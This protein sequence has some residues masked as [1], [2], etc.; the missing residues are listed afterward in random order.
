MKRIAYMLITLVPLFAVGAT[1]RLEGDRIWLDGKGA[2]LSTVLQMFEDRG[3]KVLVDPELDLD[4]L[5]GSWEDAKA[6][7]VISQLAGS[8]NYMVDWELIRGPLGDQYRLKSFRIGNEYTVR[9]L[10]RRILDVVEGPDGTK[11][12]RGEIMVSFKDGATVEDLNALLAKLGGTLLEF[13]DPPGIYRIKIG[14]NLSVE[15]AMKIAQ[16]DANV[17]TSEQNLAFPSMNVVGLPAS[18][19]TTD[20][21]NL[22]LQPGETAVAVLDSGLD[23]KYADLPFIRGTYNAVDPSA[24]IY[25]PTGHGTLTSLIASGALT[26][27]GATPSEVGVPVLSIM[28][29]DENGMTSAD[30][31]FR[32]IDFAINSGASIIN[33]SFGTGTYSAFL[34]DAV[35][36]AIA[37]GVEIFVSAGNHINTDEIW[38]AANPGVT[39]VGG[40]NPD[41]SVWEGSNEG[42]D[43]DVYEPAYATLEG[44]TSVGTSISS[45]RASHNSASS[46]DQA[47]GA[48][49]E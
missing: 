32:A 4:R 48:A 30:T 27:H 22:N 42:I 33:M 5:S 3:V 19:G 26:P 8:S 25:D 20:S 16:A 6:E 38:P 24:S 37:N 10:A 15:E 9:R 1:L 41:G 43:V 39:V 36:Y 14:D 21:V 46:T 18:L 28:A 34:D 31:L 40:L 45:P 2:T 47:A 11:Y 12:I 13:I 35:N 23:P 17:D 49:T 7:R 29:F 44:Q